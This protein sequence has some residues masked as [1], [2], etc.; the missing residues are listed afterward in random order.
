MNNPVFEIIAMV[1]GS[2]TTGSLIT[3]F[4][5]KSKNKADAQSIIGQAYGNLIDELRQSISFQGEQIKGLQEREVQY[6]KIIN[7]HQD[8]ERELRHQIKTLEI[9]LA[10]RNHK[11][12]QQS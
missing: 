2:G 10:I 5:N 12:E 11:P 4:V 7:A 6:L 3:A 1:I 8:V 9:T